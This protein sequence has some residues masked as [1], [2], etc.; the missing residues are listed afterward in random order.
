M[1]RIANYPTAV[2]DSLTFRLKSLTENNN[3]YLNSYGIR[4]GTTNWTRNGKPYAS[5]G[6]TVT[7]T[8]VNTFIKFGYN[9]GGEHISY[10][11]N[12]ISKSS[13]LGKGKVW[14]FVCPI[15][16][17]CCRKLH[18][19]GTYFLHRTAH[20]GLM[21]EKQLQSKKNRDMLG[22][23]DKAVLS[24]EVYEERYKKYFKTHYNGKETKRYKKLSY[25]IK[26]A[27]SYPSDI[28]ESLLMM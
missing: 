27:E 9:T 26:T 14:F 17:K 7:H 13:N 11:V 19:K 6:I 23:F 10:R 8:E 22:I 25:K 18:L 4:A 2:E 16:G 5:I 3:S 28:M 1:P 12:L 21:Y 15:T 24:D 20:K